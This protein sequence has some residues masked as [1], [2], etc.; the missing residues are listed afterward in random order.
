MALQITACADICITYKAGTAKTQHIEFDIDRKAFCSLK[1]GD[2]IVLI[3]NITK[4]Q[5]DEKHI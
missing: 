3:V 1:L 4:T 2:N 5:L